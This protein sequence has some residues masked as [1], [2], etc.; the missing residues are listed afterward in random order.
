MI[1]GDLRIAT[2]RPR[3]GSPN[4]KTYAEEAG[5]GD[6]ALA[7][8]RRFGDHSCRKLASKLRLL[9]TA[10]RSEAAEAG[11]AEAEK[12]TFRIIRTVWSITITLSRRLRRRLRQLRGPKQ[13]CPSA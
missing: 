8:G 6:L 5:F 9:R 13:L 4:P 12:T 7:L 10:E 2:S 11:L 1:G 3:M